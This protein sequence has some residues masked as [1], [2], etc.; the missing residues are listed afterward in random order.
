[1]RDDEARLD[2]THDHG[3]LHAEDAH[4]HP[5]GGEQHRPSSHDHADHEHHGGDPMGGTSPQDHADHH[6]HTHG[7]WEEILEKIPFLHGHSH[8]EMAVDSAMEESATGIR[9]LRNSLLILGGTAIFQVII[10]LLSHSVSLLADTIHNFSDALTA[11]PLW[12]A[13]MLARRPASRTY[14]Y[15]YG[16]AEDVAGVLIVVIIFASAVIA[17]VESV[18]KLLHPSPLHQVGWVIAA[19]I[20]GFLGNEIVAELRIRTGQQIGSAAL[21]ADGQHARVDG[22]TSLAVLIGAFGSLLGYPLVDPIVGLLITI[23]ILAIVRDAAV[24]MWRRLMDAI[25]PEEIDR[26]S[27]VAG[28]IPGVQAVNGV[29]ARWVGHRLQ[30]ELHIVVDEDLLTR[31]S[32]TIAEQVRHE[33]LHAQQRLSSVMVHVDPCGHGG[34]DPHESTQHHLA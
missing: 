11:I 6:T 29:R 24:T 5:T 8:G 13:F 31:D 12:F 7:F 32:H 17:A 34:T 19:A 18:Q 27:A 10:A 30:A 9:T 3:H 26:I 4:E 15:G 28:N 33:L 21:Q 16:R 2:H 20:V 1:M 25:E 22:F 14:T 23:A